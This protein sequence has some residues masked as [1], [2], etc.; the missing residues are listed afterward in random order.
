MIRT[1]LLYATLASGERRVAVT[2]LQPEGQGQ[3]WTCRYEIDWPEGTT[4]HFAR[5][6][7]APQAANLAQK[8]IG[9]ELHTS[10]YHTQGKL[11]RERPGDGYGFPVPNNIRH[12]LVGEDKKFEG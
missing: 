2:I 1:R 12:L 7:D 4:R 9:A 5:G 6:I 10:D 11:R 8:M 3:D